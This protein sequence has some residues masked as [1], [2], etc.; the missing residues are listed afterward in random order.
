MKKIMK[1]LFLATALTVMVLAMGVMVSAAQT[2]DKVT[3]LKQTGSSE[4]YV[5]IAW[6][7]QS[8]CT[9]EVEF[10]Y[11][12]KT[13]EKIGT[14]S[15]ESDSIYGLRN[16]RTYY[17]RVRANSGSTSNPNYG[18]YS[19]TLAVVTNPGEVTKPYQS[20]ATTNGITINWTKSEGATS[21]KIYYY[22]SGTRVL[23]GETTNTYF[24][25]KGLNN[26]Q[27]LPFSW[28]EIIPVKSSGTYKAE[29]YSEA[30]YSSNVR[31]V[32]KKVTNLGIKYFW[33][34]LNE[35]NI[36][37]NATKFHDGYQYEVYNLNGKKPVIKSYTSSN[38]STTIGNIKEYRFY[39]VRVRA[40]VIVNGKKVYG[41]WSDY[42]GFAFQPKVNISTSGSSGFKLSWKKVKYAKSYTLYMSTAQK[43]GYKKIK[44]LKKTSF[45]VTKFKNKKLK[46]RKYYYFYVVANGKMGKKKV[47]SNAEYC[48][49][50]MRY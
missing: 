23:K 6:N 25:L 39:K 49:Y 21:Y 47:K 29:G 14:R 28:I 30:I 45:K 18:A 46:K 1:S 11:D 27:D 31:L 50:A 9:Y 40:Y 38:Y 13:W 48:Y 7:E 4:T 22:I 5:Y 16:G 10:S 37:F 32:P 43:S 36:G 8:D 12:G 34:S 24:T 20:K 35:I 33:S 2:P 15:I 41:A 42:K 3:G 26:G 19:D 44:T 17:V